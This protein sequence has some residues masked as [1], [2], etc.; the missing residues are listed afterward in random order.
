M[1]NI[2]IAADDDILMKVRRLA[3]ERHTTIT[4]MVRDILERLAAR[5]DSRTEEVVAQL[6]ESFD[7]SDVVVGDL[8]WQ[9]EDL[10]AR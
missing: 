10:H 3:V 8:T 9:R 4:A 1:T 6:Q 5:E 2:T 7:A